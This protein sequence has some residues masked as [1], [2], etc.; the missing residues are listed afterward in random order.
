[1]K[2]DTVESANVLGLLPVGESTHHSRSMLNSYDWCWGREMLGGYER[3]LGE[4]EKKIHL[5]DFLCFLF[6][7]EILRIKKN[8]REKT[9]FR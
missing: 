6:G 9:E 2:F 7:I 8:L 1:M 3:G 5:G 4:L